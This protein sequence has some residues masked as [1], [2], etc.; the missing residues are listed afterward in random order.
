MK[1][2]RVKRQRLLNPSVLPIM[3]TLIVTGRNKY[4]EHVGYIFRSS[5]IFLWGGV[6]LSLEGQNS[7]M[8]VRMMLGV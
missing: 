1:M 3:K 6:A 5:F 2:A 7:L 8:L 4:S